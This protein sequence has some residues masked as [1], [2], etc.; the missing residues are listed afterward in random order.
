[1]S[2]PLVDRSLLSCAEAAYL[3]LG[4][5]TFPIWQGK[6]VLKCKSAIVTKWATFSPKLGPVGIPL[7]L[8]VL[9]LVKHNL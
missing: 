9:N 5:L 2:I 6:G 8:E 1:M 7:K 3:A 4:Q